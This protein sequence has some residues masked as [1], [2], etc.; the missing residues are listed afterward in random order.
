MNIIIIMSYFLNDQERQA[1]EENVPK[2]LQQADI[3]M[4][5]G[6]EDRQTSADVSSVSA[7]QLPDAPGGAGGAC[8]AALLKVLYENEEKPLEGSSFTQ[9]LEKMRIVLDQKGFKQIPQLSSTRPIDINETF[10][11]VPD[12]L[13]GTRRAVLI[14]I[15]YVG[16]KQGQLNGCHNDAFNMVLSILLSSLLHH[17]FPYCLHA[18]FLANQL[19]VVCFA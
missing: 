2:E 8:T 12:D 15:N 19:F 16:H 1:F 11:I 6:C 9:V 18:Y 17:F 3:W 7:F 14:G 5:S 13:P 10:K 4:I